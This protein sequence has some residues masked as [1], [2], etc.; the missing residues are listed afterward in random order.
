MPAEA[1]EILHVSGRSIPAST[2]GF[3]WQSRV[4][5]DG[6]STCNGFSTV[7]TAESAS[8]AGWGYNPHPLSSGLAHPI[9]ISV[10]LQAACG[11]GSEATSAAYRTPIDLMNGLSNYRGHGA[12][13]S[14][15]FGLGAEEPFVVVVTEMAEST[16]C[17][18]YALTVT[19]DGPWTDGDKRPSIAG[20][21]AIGD[22]LSGTNAAWRPSA[23]LTVQPRWRRCDAVGASCIDI[24]GATGSDYTVTAADIGRT[25]RF[26]NVATDV[27]GTS[28]SDSAFIEPY[29]PFEE[30]PAESLAAGDRVQNGVVG[31]APGRCGDP[32]PA[33]GVSNQGTFFLFDAYPVRSVLN[34][35]VCLVVRTVPGCAPNGV[36]PS[37]YEPAFVPESGTAANYASTSGFQANQPATASAMLPAAGS[38]DAVV[39]YPNPVGGCGQYALTLGAD[40]PFASVRPTVDGIAAEG[41]TLTA[42]NGAWSGTPAFSHSWLSCDA[43]GANCTPIGGAGGATYTPTAADVGRRLRVRVTATQ[44][45]SV[46]ADSEPT[47][48]VTAAAGAPAQPGG[49]GTAPKAAFSLARTTLQKVVRKGFI[50]VNV[51]CD[52]TSTIALEALVARRPAKRLGGKRIAKGSG[53]CQAGRRAKVKAKLTRKA[54]RGLRRR[55]SVA[56]TLNGTATDAAGNSGA[57]TKKAKL[58]RKR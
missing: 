3:R 16:G 58:K 34:E 14:Y 10:E 52:E 32:K 42:G 43:A 30:R 51:S 56:F 26:R 57:V 22:T 54:R 23:S 11:M 24:P 5:P 38:A 44:G 19:S 29:I 18:D 17:A 35:P 2:G 28:M 48:I 33:A 49:D 1:A 37:I 21:A 13:G 46:S 55:R 15:S 9:C 25:L 31:A 45:R 8:G 12:A 47:G 6:G 36:I 39:T 53:T 7:P 40:A 27:D 4:V 20:S 41:G 50:P